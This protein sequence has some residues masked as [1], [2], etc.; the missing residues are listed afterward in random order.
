[1]SHD[2]SVSLH[3]L[4]LLITANWECKQQFDWNIGSFPNCIIAVNFWMY[5][6]K[7]TIKAGAE[8]NH[9]WDEDGE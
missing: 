7:N 3:S 2:T 6:I 8:D 9:N 4:V 5:L 1:M